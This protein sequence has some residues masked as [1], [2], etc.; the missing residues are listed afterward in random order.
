MSSKYIIPQT[1]YVI[2]IYYTRNLLGQQ[3]CK[4]VQR[5]SE[6]A[7]RALSRILCTRNLL[8]YQVVRK[9]FG[10]PRAR[11]ALSLEYSIPQTYYVIK[12]V[13]NTLYKKLTML[14]KLYGILCTRNFLG[15]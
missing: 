13:W 11:S 3:S 4:E 1:Y 12:V 6:S 10:L 8:G 9:S 15:Q 5:T 14:S 2:K 7:L